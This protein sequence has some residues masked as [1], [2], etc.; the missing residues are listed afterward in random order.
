MASFCIFADSLTT[1][2]FLRSIV[3][4]VNVNVES[5]YLLCE[6]YTSAENWE[7]GFPVYY[8]DT[9]ESCIESSDIVVVFEDIIPTSAYNMI[10]EICA[11]TCKRIVLLKSGQDS[12]KHFTDENIEKII[13]LCKSLPVILLLT[14]GAISQ[15][16]AGNVVLC[17]SLDTKGVNILLHPC[18][19]AASIFNSLNQQELLNSAIKRMLTFEDK[20]DVIVWHFDLGDYLNK[21]DSLNLFDRIHP[22]FCILL[23]NATTLEK[24]SKI[25]DR[26]NHVLKK[27][28]DVTI[29]TRYYAVTVGKNNY[30]FYNGEF[31]RNA[32]N[33]LDFESS[34]IEEIIS[35]A[36]ISKLTYP[37][38]IIPIY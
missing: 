15:P 8:R 21:F 35:Q 10:K 37:K 23:S 16:F 4:L 18:Y 1:R 3:Y 34:E 5:V 13:N 38:G 12:A 28:V 26:I 9:I 24:I 6:N 36:I 27:S 2:T 25:R 30:S 29:T 19:P 17:K 11:L 7:Y 31:S 20:K 14:T 22:D 32:I 33:C